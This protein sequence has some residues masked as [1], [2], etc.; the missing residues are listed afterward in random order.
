M[1]EITDPEL[2]AQLEAPETKADSATDPKA[3]AGKLATVIEQINRVQ[4]LYDDDIAP[5]KYG[6]ASSVADY[7]PTDTNSR[8]DV[9]GTQLS[10]KGLAAFRVPGTGTVT[11]RDAAVFERAN[12]PTS[13]TRDV[14]IEE[15]LRGMR[16]RIDEEL[17]ALG[18]P[19]AK[20]TGM[21]SPSPSSETP[22][23]ESRQELPGVASPDGADKSRNLNEIDGGNS[24]A[25]VGYETGETRYEDDPQL[26]GVKNEYR[27]RLARGDSGKDLVA[28]LKSV[29]VTDESIF[30]SALKQADF[31]RKNPNV[32]IGNY[33]IEK[34]DDKAIPQDWV[35]QRMNMV[36]GSPVG[37][38]VTNFGDALTGF[39]LDSL[40]GD[41]AL[42]RAGMAQ[43]N[44]DNP[45]A[46][47]TG[48]VLGGMAAVAGGE[49]AL[50]RAG[51][52][53]A[54]AGLAADALY[55]AGAGAG[56]NDEDRLTGALTGT[57]AG[58][59]GNVAGNAI[60]KTAGRAIAGVSD[61]SV[62]ALRNSGVPM[63]V[64]QTVGQSGRFGG[65][66]KGIEDRLSGLPI[67][68][69]AI[70][71]RRR[72]GVQA[73]NSK[74]FDHA[75]KP[76]GGTVGGEVGES[77]VEQAQQLVSDAY[78]TALAGK[79]V[80]PDKPFATALTR[81]VINVTDL[82][83]VGGEVASSVEAILEPYM[84][85]A[86]LTGDAMQ[87]ISR[88]LQGL[89][90]AYKPDAL[91]NRI[92]KALDEVEESVF[93]LFR[94]QAPEVLPA[95]NRAK[96][97]YR[98]L[99][100]VE[101]AVNK[102]KNQEG[103]FTP[104][105]LGQADRSGMSKFGGKKGAAAGRSPFHNFQRDAQKVLPNNV[106]DSGTAGRQA[107]AMLLPAAAGG[108]GYATSDDNSMSAGLTLAGVTALAFSR[109][110][111][112]MAAAAAAKRPSAMRSAGTAIKGAA[113][114]VGALAGGASAATAPPA[115]AGD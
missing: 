86:Q 62:N 111:Q 90:A 100:I 66:I 33:N 38:G 70:N 16:A 94:R 44:R 45:G 23:D 78:R 91:S 8:F 61:P 82:P 31:R 52:S 84:Q 41:P 83:R 104:A 102:A 50:A 71:A 77:A 36:A 68:G 92:G 6:I 85:G 96:A 12:M 17:R 9:A 37:V 47:L 76:I 99:S 109:A 18:L 101:D 3:R 80:A 25:S 51:L 28:Y 55:G 75:L 26:A 81:S 57:A 5:E 115:L 24:G 10:E 74:A 40:T 88:E 27:S 89:K 32:P 53:G 20:W 11:D 30:R 69:E 56:S 105:Q 97:A 108:A 34:L 19:A 7:L 93:G 46:A 54:R 13:G 48:Q 42:T 43:L 72:E 29:G 114:K 95:Y 112:R 113:R 58:L 59:A 14:A 98:R 106:P 79:V 22:P 67:V 39:N 103:V 110:G 60:T 2:L 49:A 1:P 15:Q 21:Q 87:Q 63:T 4:Q 107:A 65:A 35:R 64:G 73:F